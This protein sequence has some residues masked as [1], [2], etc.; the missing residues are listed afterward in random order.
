MASWTSEMSVTLSL[1]LDEVVGT[2]EMVKTR[3]D[4]CKIYDHLTSSIRTTA[5]YFTGSKA[6]GLQL[7]GS[8]E[9]YMFDINDELNIKVKHMMQDTHGSFSQILHLCTANVPPGFAILRL[10]T[11]C[12]DPLLLR[13][14]QGING[15]PHLSS[16]LF[17]RECLHNAN[18]TNVTVSIQGPSLEMWGPYADKSGS[19]TD[20][21]PSIHCP[22]WPSGAEEWIKRPRHYGWPTPRDI[23]DIT[24]FG[25][26]LVPV[27]HPLSPHKDME[28]RISFSV[29]ER[30]L[31]WA[32]NHVQIQCYAMLKII[33]KEFI[34]VKCVVRKT[35]YCVRTLSKRFYFGNLKTRRHCFGVQRISGIALFSCWSNSGNVYKKD[36]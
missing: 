6:E 15:V 25:C 17:M 5:V 16:V 29:A 20:R 4:F 12:Q 30:T 8:D 24:N 23:A 9:D 19:G 21:V 36:Y 28:W 11:H 1:L 35:M 26:H 7:P 18:Q 31:V 33:F 32:F 13:I 27:S 2:A 10:D 14:S 3:Q 22:F 34:K